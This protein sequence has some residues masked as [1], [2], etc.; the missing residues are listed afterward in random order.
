MRVNK[1]WCLYAF[2]L[3]WNRPVLSYRDQLVSFARI[4]ASD[5]PSLPYAIAVKRINLSAVAH[6]FNDNLLLP[7]KACT[8]AER[9]TLGGS[10]RLTAQTL[11]KVLGQMPNMIA[12]DLNRVM[13]C[14]DRVLRTVAETAPGLQGLNLNGCAMVGD[15]S[16]KL[17]AERCRLMR[18]VSK[19]C[20]ILMT[21]ELIS[22]LQLKV[23]G[24]L[25][26]SDESLVA[27]AR[28]CPLLLEVDCAELPLLTSATIY[29]F[30]LNSTEIRELKAAQNTFIDSDA[31]PNLP[32]LFH[33]T[34]AESQ[35][36]AIHA[37]VYA[38]TADFEP[39]SPGPLRMLR[40][41]APRLDSLKVVDLTNCSNFGDRGLKNL[42]ESAPRLRL[43]TLAKCG[44]LSDEGV[45]HIG[46]LGKY[47][48]HLHLAHLSL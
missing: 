8:R 13:L 27:V 41:S 1:T 46:Q 16:M 2:S 47:L 22:S 10:S 42:V 6:S 32:D 48:H 3:L 11:A 39:L 20:C 24:C 26:L 5:N 14:D 28:S 23:N 45:K 4:L 7:W 43:L 9:V 25:R 38:T 31:F 19:R 30:L 34:E 40:P 35:S 29:A 21:T 15:E 12:L 36:M 18:R 17:V 37:R 44:Q 33:M